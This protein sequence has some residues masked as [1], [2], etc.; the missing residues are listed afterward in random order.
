[1]IARK[2]DIKKKPLTDEEVDR[3]AETCH[4]GYVGYSKS[5]YDEIIPRWG[6]L[7]ESGKKWARDGVRRGF[8]HG[9]FL[10]AEDNHQHWMEQKAADGWVYGPVKDQ[11]A[12]TH[13]AMVPYD[14]LPQREKHKDALFS[15]IAQAMHY[16]VEQE[17]ES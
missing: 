14:Q 6:D 13:P 5:H 15:S 10:R 4:E 1:M 9:L 16:L 8:E 2:T 12:K 11:I 17:R 7:D 3:I